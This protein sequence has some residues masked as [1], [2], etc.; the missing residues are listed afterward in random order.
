MKSVINKVWV[1]GLVL[2]VLAACSKPSRIT[3]KIDPAHVGEMIYLYDLE[4]DMQQPIDSM[5]TLTAE[6]SMEFTPAEAGK[7]YLLKAADRHAYL[8]PEAGTI[9]IDS[10]GLAGGTPLNDELREYLTQH[11]ALMLAETD[12]SAQISTLAKNFFRKHKDE[13]IG[14]IGFMNAYMVSESMEEV[15]QLLAEA[16]TRLLKVSRLADMSAAFEQM[17]KTAPGEMFLDFSAQTPSGEVAKLSDYVGKG[18]YVLLDFW[19][20]WC[21][22]CRRE[23]PHLSAVYEKYRNKGLVVLGIN[24]WERNEGDFEK[25]VE[26]LKI[27]YPQLVTQGQEATALYGILGIPQIMLI[28]PDGKVVARDLHGEA[29]EA[30]I[31][32]LY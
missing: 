12:E 14:Y 9:T 27:P 15:E 13:I 11:N 25:A 30:A 1:A 17:K 2:L 22:P 23:I 19:A 7:L 10:L 6:Y 29:I 20:S 3:G 24:V 28:G 8:I 21:G 4:G 26:Q 5:E 18:Q 16:G 31:A 32:P